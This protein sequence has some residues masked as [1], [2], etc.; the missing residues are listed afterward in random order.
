[1]TNVG[2]INENNDGQKS[3]EIVTLN[4]IKSDYM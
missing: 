3:R 1:M 4:D 2:M